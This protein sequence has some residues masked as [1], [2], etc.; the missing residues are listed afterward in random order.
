MQN[1]RIDWSKAALA[2]ACTPAMSSAVYVQVEKKINNYRGD[3]AVLD[4][5]TKLL[6]FNSNDT[7]DESED[8]E[9]P[10]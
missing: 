3:D 4:D 9:N 10:V 2:V 1:I 5:I 6:I 7:L 8:D